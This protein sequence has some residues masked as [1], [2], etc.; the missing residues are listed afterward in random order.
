VAKLSNSPR[1]GARARFRRLKVKEGAEAWARPPGGGRP[2]HYHW[3]A[4]AWA[5]WAGSGSSLPPP[6]QWRP[7]LP[8][9]GPSLSAEPL[10]A[11]LW[12]AELATTP[13]PLG[14]RGHW[15]PRARAATVTVRD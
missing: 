12:Q 13:S 15:Q 6:D 8:L 5:T 3:Q 14:L 2:G 4:H 11:S 1:L 10:A 7:C 9:T